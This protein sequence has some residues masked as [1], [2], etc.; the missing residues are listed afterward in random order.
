[1]GGG[2][3]HRSRDLRRGGAEIATRKGLVIIG[4]AVF[5]LLAGGAASVYTYHVATGEVTTHEPTGNIVTSNVAESQPVWDE[6]MPY[7]IESGETLW[8]I[9]TGN[10]TSIS[11]QWP[12]TGEHF[13]K[14]N[15]STP[16]DGVTFVYT[17]ED[18]YQ[19]DLYDLSEL[20]LYDIDITGL[21]V[22][23]R[24]SG[25]ADGGSNVTGYAN[26]VIK[27]SGEAFAGAE[28]SQLGPVFVTRSYRW[29]TNPDTSTAWTL[30]EIN[31]LQA[32]ARIKT[33]DT[34]AAVRLTQ[35]TVTVGYLETIIEGSTPTGSLFTVTPHPDFN[36]YLQVRVY[37]ANTGDLIKTYDYLNLHLRLEDSVEASGIPGYEILSLENGRVTFNLPGNLNGSKTISVTGGSYRL[38]SA[39]TTNWEEGWTVTPELYL[40]LSQR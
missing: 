19:V 36:D 39:N 21:T 2:L 12:D 31:E 23:F 29:D 9:S 20:E 37:L 6:M 30:D 26:A 22:G 15:E 33:G 8:L 3:E 34:D 17:Y 1:M 13:D 7:I 35:V 11:G 18:S 5:L 27:T 10:E 14:V 40:D 24:F 25:G 16:D 28:E 32:G 4:A 38:V